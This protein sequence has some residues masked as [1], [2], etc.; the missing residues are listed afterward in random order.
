MASPTRIFGAE[1]MLEFSNS[2]ISTMRVHDDANEPLIAINE[3]AMAAMKS[4]EIKNV[5][6]N[7]KY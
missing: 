1:A 4:M 5:M 7:S 6:T 2:M 3:K